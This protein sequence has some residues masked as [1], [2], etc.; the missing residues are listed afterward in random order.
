MRPSRVLVAQKE[1]KRAVASR[2]NRIAA[3]FVPI[4]LAAAAPGKSEG[5]LKADFKK[6]TTEKKPP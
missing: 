1:Y 3:R 6:A 2:P 4:I 5:E